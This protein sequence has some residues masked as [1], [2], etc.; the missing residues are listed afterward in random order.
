MRLRVVDQSLNKEDQ[1]LYNLELWTRLFKTVSQTFQNQVSTDSRGTSYDREVQEMWEWIICGKVWLKIWLTAEN[2]SNQSPAYWMNTLLKWSMATFWGH[3]Q[4]F[5]FSRFSKMFFNR[6]SD[7]KN[8]N[9]KI[10]NLAAPKG[11][12]WAILDALDVTFFDQIANCVPCFQ[13]I[14][15]IIFKRQLIITLMEVFKSS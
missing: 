12:L 8:S 6:T 7:F 15:V 2:H 11:W 5:Q 3:F 9:R 1:H 4:K 13:H 10:S 14:I